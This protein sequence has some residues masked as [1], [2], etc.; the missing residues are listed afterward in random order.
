MIDDALIF[1]KDR[2]NAHLRLGLDEIGSLEDQV[3]F[4]DGENT[5]PLTFKLGAVTALMINIEEEN[6]L[7]AP[8][9]YAQIA[10]DGTRRDAQP[11][12]RLNLFVIFVARYK[13][14]QDSLR[15]LSDIIRYFQANRVFDHQSAPELSDQI[16]QLIVELVTQPFSEQNEIWNALRIPYHPSVLYKVRMVVFRTPLAP[17]QPEIEERRL[18]LSQ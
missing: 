6:I 17:A 3:V 2:L 8:N 16:E 11:D 15:Y 9:Q 13:Q 7:R 18:E 4:L 14:Y 12:I 5:E 1:L 10:P